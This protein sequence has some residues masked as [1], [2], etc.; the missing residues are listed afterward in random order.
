MD[1]KILSSC[2]FL[3]GYALA[4][5]LCLEGTKSYHLI[6]GLFLFTYFTYAIIKS[7]ND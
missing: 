5:A 1:N 3:F 7:Y 4:F 6:G 2:Y